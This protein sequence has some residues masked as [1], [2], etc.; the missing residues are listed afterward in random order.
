MPPSFNT[1]DTEAASLDET[2]TD[3]M[4]VPSALRTIAGSE[5]IGA[6]ASRSPASPA[7]RNAGSL[8]VA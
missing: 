5:T 7:V 8:C 4:N 1:Q 6:P 3:T 2:T